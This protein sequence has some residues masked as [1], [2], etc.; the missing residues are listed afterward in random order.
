MSRELDG[1]GRDFERFFRDCEPRLRLALVAA[2]GAVDGRAATSDALSWAW[3]NWERLADMQNPC[4]YLFKVGRTSIRRERWRPVQLLPAGAVD[5]V[6]VVPELLPAL[7]RLSLLQ[8]TAVLL[9]HGY[10]WSQRE[11]ANMLEITPA[12]VHQ[13]V[14]R[15]TELLRADLG[16]RDVC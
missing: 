10:G 1:R 6:D 8:R 14:K 12:T 3:E 5:P 15:G 7:R 11:V 4:G 13:H 16:V 2:F 9:V